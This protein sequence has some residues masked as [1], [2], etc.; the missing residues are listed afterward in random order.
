VD[1]ALG[2][3]DR[4][5]L[6]PV[7]AALVLEVRPGVGP[8]HQERHLVEAPHV[9]RGAGQDLE[10]P[11][12]AHGV[13]LVHLEQVAGE[14]VGLLAALGAAD[15]DDDGLAVVGVA[16]EEEQLQLLVEAGDVGLGLVDLPPGQL[17]LVADGV[18]RQLTGHLEIGRP[19]VEGAGD[20][21]HRLELLVPARER[22]QL[23]LVD[24]DLGVGEAGLHG[25][26]LAR[27][28][29]QPLLHPVRLPTGRRRGPR[30]DRPRRRRPAPPRRA[31]SGDR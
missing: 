24:Q 30:R 25:L 18:G 10:R 31:A 8:L 28:L 2:L 4:H 5:P 27:Q 14:E 9:G 22:P 26:Q 23:L 20:G 19:L 13:G 3:G 17:A 16:R 6:H 29:V 1:P 7:G 21:D 11:A 12:A 15:L